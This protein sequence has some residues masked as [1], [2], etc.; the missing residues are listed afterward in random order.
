MLK[1][2]LPRLALPLL[3]LTLPA[4]ALAQSTA[5]IPGPALRC[6]AVL[7]AVNQQGAALVDT[8]PTTYDRLVR[9]VGFCGIEQ[10]TEPLYGP[11]ADTPQCFLG[12]RC[13]DRMDNR[14]G[15]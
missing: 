5:R 2:A 10:T 15:D 7:A 12:Y 14:R 3:A 9:D 6:G 8:G 11:A 4:T 1:H 13:R